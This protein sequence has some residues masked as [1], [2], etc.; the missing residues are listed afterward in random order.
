MKHQFFS[1]AAFFA[2]FI[3]L[4]YNAPV[5]AD[6]VSVFRTNGGNY[7]EWRFVLPSKSGFDTLIQ[8]TAEIVKFENQINDHSR[9]GKD[10]RK[11]FLNYLKSWRDNPKNHLDLI[12]LGLGY[13]IFGEVAFYRQLPELV[14][15]ADRNDLCLLQSILIAE[16]WP[17]H[18]FHSTGDYVAIWT[19]EEIK[20]YY[21]QSDQPK[22]ATP[23]AAT[24]V[25]ESAPADSTSPSAIN[26]SA[27]PADSSALVDWGF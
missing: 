1:A 20:N 7:E 6:T 24:A 3:A 25:S 18:S 19:D 16:H 2:I 8:K 4:L 12:L 10:E 22:V 9:L 21:G 17:M 13:G 26:R 11:F 14:K 23:A 15:I 5:S 27:K